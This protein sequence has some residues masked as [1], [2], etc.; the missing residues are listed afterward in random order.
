MNYTEDYKSHLI[1]CFEIEVDDWMEE[2]CDTEVW[3]LPATAKEEVR[4]LSPIFG[5]LTD[6]TFNLT[7]RVSSDGETADIEMVLRADLPEDSGIPHQVFAH[8]VDMKGRHCQ[9]SHDCCGNWYH[10]KVNV[11]HPTGT[12]RWFIRYTSYRNI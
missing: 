12:N 5:L 11:T 9:H 7:R 4:K 6:P 8:Y 2:E 10:G 3:V 1:E